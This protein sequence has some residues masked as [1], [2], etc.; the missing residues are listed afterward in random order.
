MAGAAEYAAVWMLYTEY[1][2]SFHADII[3]QKLKGM[4]EVEKEW[5]GNYDCTIRINI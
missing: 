5:K 4:D 2:R 1:S 3:V